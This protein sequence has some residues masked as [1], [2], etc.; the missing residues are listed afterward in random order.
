MRSTAPP[1]APEH[2]LLGTVYIDDG[3]KSSGRGVP[4]VPLAPQVVITHGRQVAPFLFSVG[5]ETLTCFMLLQLRS[6]ASAFIFV[7]MRAAT[8]T[9]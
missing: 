9:Y 3:E 5:H 6:E 4:Q 2:D 7:A 8:S 1:L